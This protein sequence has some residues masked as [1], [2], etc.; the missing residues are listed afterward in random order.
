MCFAKLKHACSLQCC[1]ESNLE[2]QLRKDLVGGLT[3]KNEKH[4]DTKLLKFS[5]FR[6]LLEFY[7]EFYLFYLEF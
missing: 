2:V 1:V 4:D 3:G 5:E 6:I 7:L